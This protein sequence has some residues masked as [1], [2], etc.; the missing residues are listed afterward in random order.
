MPNAFTPNNDGYNDCYGLKYWGVIEALD[1]TIYNRWGAKVFHTNKPGDCWDGRYRGEPQNPDV[2][3]Y[4][5]SA[6]TSCGNVE[7]KGTFVLI[8]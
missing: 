6:K 2:Y 5:I 4:M 3:V 7:R 8:R 1:F